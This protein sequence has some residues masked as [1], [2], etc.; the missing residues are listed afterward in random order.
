MPP[1]IILGKRGR[2]ISKERQPFLWR[3]VKVLEFLLQV[4]N[5]APWQ[6]RM[7][8][9]IISFTLNQL[10]LE[11]DL[12][13]PS[14]SCFVLLLLIRGTGVGCTHFSISKC[15]KQ[16]GNWVSVQKHCDNPPTKA[17][18]LSLA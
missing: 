3:D 14:F 16:P 13:S 7:L 9:V 18:A 2:E 6:H 5:E 8:G 10:D 4:G 11:F 15:P 12:S 1:L 17:S